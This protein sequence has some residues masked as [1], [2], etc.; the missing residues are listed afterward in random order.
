MPKIRGTFMAICN[1]CGG[2][3]DRTNHWTRVIC[4]KCRAILKHERYEKT[5]LVHISD[6]K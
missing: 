4:I 6:N 5:K 1:K 2:G 3:E